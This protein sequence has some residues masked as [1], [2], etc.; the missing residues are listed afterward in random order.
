MLKDG[1][2]LKGG[3]VRYNDKSGILNYENGSDTRSLM[4]RSVVAF[5]FFDDSKGSQRIYYS[6]EADDEETGIKRYYF[7]EVLKEFK[8]FAVLSMIAPLEIEQRSG[9]LT[10]NDP[11]FN[12]TQN[13]PRIE[14]TQMETIYFMSRDGNLKPYLKIIE[15]DIDDAWF[16]RTHTK[17][18][19]SMK[20]FFQSSPETNGRS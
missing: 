12:A 15:K 13:V 17:T 5:E 20:K 1:T 10:F 2:E 8:N 4:P 9:R 16:D 6:L 3:L 18:S 7:F 19:L 14:Y 11:T